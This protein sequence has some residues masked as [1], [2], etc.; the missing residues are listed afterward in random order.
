MLQILHIVLFR[1]VKQCSVCFL[2]FLAVLYCTKWAFNSHNYNQVMILETEA[3]LW[4]SQHKA[5]IS[6]TSHLLQAIQR[7][8]GHTITC[9]SLLESSMRWR[10]RF[11]R[12]SAH[13]AVVL[14]RWKT[15]SYHGKS[16]LMWNCVPS[17]HLD[18]FSQKIC[19]NGA[20]IFR[21][22]FVWFIFLRKFVWCI[23]CRKCVWCI[24]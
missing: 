6:L 22:K 9:S 12:N 19:I 5:K 13:N 1:C 8:V 24:S 18:D 7:V 10:R 14:S 23:F 4:A 20:Y 17:R 16:R 2:C 21:R 3:N 15:T 11:C